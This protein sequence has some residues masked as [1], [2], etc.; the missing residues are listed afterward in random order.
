MVAPFLTNYGARL[1]VDYY[2]RDRF[3]HIFASGTD[4][5]A[6]LIGNSKRQSNVIRDQEHAQ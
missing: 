6:E 1:S 2:S 5:A 4:P 3:G